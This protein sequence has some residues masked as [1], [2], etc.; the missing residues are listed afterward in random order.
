[1]WLVKE[2]GGSRPQWG[3]DGWEGRKSRFWAASDFPQAGR[4]PVLADRCSECLE[5]LADKIIKRREI[6]VHIASFDSKR[7]IVLRFAVNNQMLRNPVTGRA[8]PD[9]ARLVSQSRH[10]L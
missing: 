6:V 7:C 5:E 8:V 3:S 1:M 9:D 10:E 4:T 2:S